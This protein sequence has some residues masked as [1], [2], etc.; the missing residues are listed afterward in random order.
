MSA[1]VI[2]LI[3]IIAL[4]MFAIMIINAIAA[5]DLAKTQ[6]YKD[7]SQNAGDDLKNAK[8]S[9][10]LMTWAAILTGLTFFF[11]IAAV[12]FYF[13]MSNKHVQSYGQ[14]AM[15]KAFGPTMPMV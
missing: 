2:S 1:V 12:I 10:S 4:T 8:K 3:V 15:N 9:H 5:S 6:C 13:V 14:Q 7:G 11:L